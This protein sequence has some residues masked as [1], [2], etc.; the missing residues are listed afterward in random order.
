MTKN[1]QKNNVLNAFEEGSDRVA[2][3]FKT[4][5]NMEIPEVARDFIKRAAAVAKDRVDSAHGN[6]EKAT[7]AAEGAITRSV[8]V[9]ASIVRSAEN[10]LYQD[11]EAFV[12]GVNQLASAGSL[13]EAFKIQSNYLLAR[14]EVAVARVKSVADYL[15][16][17][18]SDGANS[19][20]ES[21]VKAA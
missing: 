10:A 8:G 5:G 16:R 18:F 1:T 11:L 7:A 3:T 6:A 9:V 15:G 20:Q 13:S 4:I 17:S 19:V 2:E 14:N 12:T 21:F